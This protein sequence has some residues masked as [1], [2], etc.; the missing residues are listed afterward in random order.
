MTTKRLVIILVVIVALL[1]IFSAY[2]S[3]R[4]FGYYGYRGVYNGA[5]YLYWNDTKYYRDKSVRNG[6]RGNNGI[7]GGG[8]GRGK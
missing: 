7:R 2:Y 6:S 5:S 1:L 3:G 4:G 8:P